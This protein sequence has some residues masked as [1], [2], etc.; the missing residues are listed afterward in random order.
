MLGQRE[1]LTD[2]VRVVVRLRRG[3]DAAVEVRALEAALQRRSAIG[4]RYTTS[5]SSTPGGYT[6]GLIAIYHPT[7]R[8]RTHAPDML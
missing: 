6:T 7:K 1:R 2:E 3:G 8:T 5:H 4:A